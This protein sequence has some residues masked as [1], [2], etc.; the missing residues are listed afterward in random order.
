VSVHPYLQWEAIFGKF[1]HCP[2]HLTQF[3]PERGYDAHADITT[4]RDRTERE[5]NRERGASTGREER[6]FSRLRQSSFDVRTTAGQV[7]TSQR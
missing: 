3:T 1:V 7:I 4:Q 6:S 2:T 5:Y